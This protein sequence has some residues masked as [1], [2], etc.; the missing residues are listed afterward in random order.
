MSGDVRPPTHSQDM[1]NI[2]SI[3]ARLAT[4]VVA[5]LGIVMSACQPAQPARVGDHDLGVVTFDHSD[6]YAIRPEPRSSVRVAAPGSNTGGN[7]RMVGVDHT[8]PFATDQTACAT[9]SG[10]A[11]STVQPGVAVRA[12][13][14]ATGTRAITMTNNV[15]FG[16]RWIWNLHLAD[17]GAAN[18][19]AGVTA[20]DYSNI[21]GATPSGAGSRMAVGFCLR[22]AGTTVTSKVWPLSSPEPSW[23]DPTFVRRADVGPELVFPGRTGWYMGHLAPGEATTISAH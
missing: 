23:S 15:M 18:P 9:W 7:L 17:S 2:K 8:A 20:F 10:S 19:M 11:A 5:C 1:L 16:A 14:T 3:Q 12:S 21:F 4:I 13:V 22:V 6:T